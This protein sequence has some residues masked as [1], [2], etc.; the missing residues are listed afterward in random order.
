MNNS[1][2]ILD[3]TLRDG[4]YYNNWDFE[5]ELVEVYLRSMEKASIDVVEIGFRSP[6]VTSFM[7]PYFYSTDEY[8]STLPLPNDLMIGVMINAKEYLD[9]AE[10]PKKII[11]K[12]FKFAQSSPVDIVRIAINFDQARDAEILVRELKLLGYKVGLNLMQAQ[13]KSSQLYLETAKTLQAW[14]TVDVLYFADSLGSMDPSQVSFIC[15]TLKKIWEGPLGIHTHNNKGMALNN[16]LAA[17]DSGVSWCDSTI[18]GMGRG[19]GNV[20]TEALMLE[21]VNQEKHS[22]IPSHLNEC[23]KYFEPLLKEYGWGASPYYHYAANHKIHPTFVMH[24]LNEPRYKQE[25]IFLT[26]DSLAKKSSTSFSDNALRNAVYGNDSEQINGAWDATGW[27]E[28]RSVM[29]IGGGPSVGK[30]KKAIQNYIKNNRP[31]VL[32]LNINSHIPNSIGDATVV[33]YESWALLDP[34]RYLH[35]KHPLILPASRLSTNSEPKAEELNILDY[36]LTLQEGAF[37]IRPKGCH[38]QW[39]LTIAYAL[40]VVTQASANQILMVGF[41]GYDSNDPRQEEMNEVIAAYARLKNCL[42]LKS[43]TPT[44]YNIFQGS[45]FEPKVELN[46]FVLVIPARYQSSRFPG[47]P[48]ADLCGKS[49]LRHVWD[50]CVQAVGTENVLIATDDDR[51][52]AHCS[53]QGM[54]VIMTSNQCST[55]TDRVYEV[56]KKV[57]RKI[58]INVQGDEPLIDPNDVIKILETSRKYQGDI[59]NGMC[60]IEVRDDFFSPNVPKVVCSN[61]GKLL[62]MSRATVPT[63]K[64]HEFKGGMRQVCIYAFPR[65]IILEFGRQE[66]KTK[67][68]EIEDIEILRFLEMGYDVRMVEVKGSSVA[69]DTPEDLE[70]AKA[71][72]NDG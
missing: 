33:S 13:E 22:G 71:I 35:L 34:E 37:E 64:N 40:C 68:E 3:C 55:G 5:H 53:D 48:L 28:N 43:L 38:L 58:Y 50:K 52:K 57:K 72:V 25:Q 67:L 41:D 18:M 63:D 49:L 1:L 70:R 51:I 32:F 6:P 20:T 21:F 66:E 42:P 36:G 11:N 59:I 44:N 17:I 31:A 7:G 8:L 26:L 29:L 65:N 24:L 16:S 14:E 10:E 12:M 2:T 47:K 45:I 19:A 23:R 30:Y 60:P 9:V 46:D 69:V 61:D 54:Q 62:Y 39:S 4:G 27:L 15:S 56:A